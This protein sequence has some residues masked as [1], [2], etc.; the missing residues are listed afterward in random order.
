[1]GIEYAEQIGGDRDGLFLRRSKSCPD[2][3]I[4]TT[5]YYITLEMIQLGG[6]AM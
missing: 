3:C 4:A 1:M 2:R 5:P 6:M